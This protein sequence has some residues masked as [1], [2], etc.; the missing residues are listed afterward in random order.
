MWVRKFLHG[1][2]LPS[3]DGAMLVLH[4]SERLEVLQFVGGPFEQNTLLLVDPGLGEAVAVDPGAATPD[5]LRV[6]EQRGLRLKEIW[7]THAHL[8][9]VEGIPIVLASHPVPVRMHP[10][11][12]PLY[13]RV[14]DQ[15]GAFGL[16]MAGVLPDA[17]MDLVPGAPC[18][19]GAIRLEIR[20][21]PGH[22][23]GHV[24]LVAHEDSFAIVGDVIFQR[25]IGRT[26]LPG[27]DFQTLLASIRTAILTLPD[28]FALFPGHGPRTTVGEERLGNPFL[29]PM[30]GADRA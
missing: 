30:M 3:E 10:A 24:I 1:L 5:L 29:T 23:P 25:S 22:A 9:H 8:D 17:V 16:P 6:V 12:L 13:A 19:V 4:T 2:T 21:S 26:D 14:S 11:D 20:E 28:D 7:L 18:E 27:G 15:A